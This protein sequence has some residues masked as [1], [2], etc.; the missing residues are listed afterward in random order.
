VAGEVLNIWHV[1][2]EQIGHHRDPEAYAG[3][4]GPAHPHP[5]AAYH[6][7]KRRVGNQFLSREREFRKRSLEHVVALD[8]AMPTKTGERKRKQGLGADCY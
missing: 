4:T 1:L 5:R 3:K 8:A 6:L 7:A 2:I